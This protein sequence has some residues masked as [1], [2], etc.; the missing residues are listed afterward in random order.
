MARK[1]FGHCSTCHGEH[2]L[3][4]WR[5][6]RRVPCAVDGCGIATRI[7]AYDLDD[8]DHANFS[9]V[10]VR[11]ALIWVRDSGYTQVALLQPS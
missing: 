4:D 2:K 5:K 10:C 6:C 11:H 8:P 7:V 9:F 3:S 1:E